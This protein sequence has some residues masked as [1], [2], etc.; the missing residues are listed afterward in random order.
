[1]TH[2]WYRLDKPIT[3]FPPVFKQS[4]LFSTSRGLLITCKECGGVPHVIRTCS[5]IQNKYQV[6]P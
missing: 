5:N 4:E 2:P 6:A 1:M 3:T